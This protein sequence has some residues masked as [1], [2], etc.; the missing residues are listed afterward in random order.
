MLRSA[1]KHSR[2]RRAIE[3]VFVRKFIPILITRFLT[4]RSH[5]ILLNSKCSREIYWQSK[6]V[7]DRQLVRS[8]KW[9]SKK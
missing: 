6:R 7:S 3:L 1:L 2:F 8:E 9:R 5:L 4:D